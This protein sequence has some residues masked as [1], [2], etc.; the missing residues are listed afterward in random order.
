MEEFE[1]CQ[2]KIMT[3]QEYFAKIF[4]T[5][6]KIIIE[7][8]RKMSA[9]SGRTG[10]IDKL[11]EENE[12]RMNRTLALL[13]RHNHGAENVSRALIARLQK[14]DRA[15]YNLFRRPSGTTTRGLKTLFNFA[16]ELANIGPL[17]VLKKEKAEKILRENP[18]Q[19]IIKA[20]KYRNV[21]E[22]LVK[23][24][25]FEVFSALRF[26][27]SKEWMHRVFDKTY[28]KLSPN[29]FE[30]RRVDLRVLSGKWLK[31]AEKFVQKKYHNISH[32]KELGVIFVIPLKI[33]TPGE[34]LR[35]FSLILHYLHEVSFYSELFKKASETASFGKKIISLLKGEVL[36]TLPRAKSRG[37]NWLIIQ[38]YL[39][40]DNPQDPRLF[41]P[42]L[43]PEA[44]HWE[45]AEQDISHFGKRFDNIDLEMWLEL[46]WVGGYFKSKVKSQKSKLVSFDL[47][48]NIMSL[49]K[50][51]EIAKYLYH[52]QEALWNHIFEE[53]MGREKLEKLMIENFDKG[54]IKL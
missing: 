37:I 48:D 28:K 14:D 20:F 54:F 6:S 41:I 29:D 30:K 5:K 11:V 23:E 47:I 39:A 26:V 1:N 9:I 13:N 33:D 36:E 34:T 7:M 35:L 25:L 2:I 15:L 43:S 52:H 17:F 21:N 42:H 50:K 16:L 3:P 19:N 53:Y 4:R 32:L 18:P 44:I 46:D 27:E 49:V 45:K 8:D 12:R 10:V 38:R 40:K 51:K 24:D 31:I 22:L